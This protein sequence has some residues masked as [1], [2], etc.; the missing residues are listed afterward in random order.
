MYKSL[1]DVERKRLAGPSDVSS[2]PNDLRP[3]GSIIPHRNIAAAAAVIGSPDG[4][5]FTCLTETGLR[6][7]PTKKRFFFVLQ[8][9]ANS[10]RQNTLH[11]VVLEVSYLVV[12]PTQ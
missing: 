4:K 10:A 7:I 6:G 8:I 2:A 12:S 5:L 3:R 1:I 11:Y 9:A